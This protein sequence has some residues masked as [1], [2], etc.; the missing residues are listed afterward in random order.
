MSNGPE[1]MRSIAAQSGGIY[2]RT[3]SRVTQ[4]H[5][6]NRKWAGTG[7][8]GPA[9]FIHDSFDRLFHSTNHQPPPPHPQ[10]VQSDPISTFIRSLP[11]DDGLHQHPVA[12]ITHPASKKSNSSINTSNEETKADQLR[13]PEED[14]QNVTTKFLALQGKELFHSILHLIHHL[15]HLL[16]LLLLLRRRSRRRRKINIVA[17]EADEADGFSFL[18]VGGFFVAFF[19]EFPFANFRVVS[20]NY[21]LIEKS[22][23][24][25]KLF[26]DWSPFSMTFWPFNLV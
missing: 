3:G 10:S 7:T 25:S 19:I 13:P 9:T 23:M 15:I 24:P 22:K 12:P 14:T 4:S 26:V 2:I 6:P 5:P 11:S 16:L 17:D 21:R 20:V 18:M 8:S 1:H